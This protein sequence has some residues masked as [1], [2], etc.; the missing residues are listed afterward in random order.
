MATLTDSI[1]AA[2]ARRFIRMLSGVPEAHGR[3][4]RRALNPFSSLRDPSI[5]RLW[6]GCVRA[7]EFIQMLFLG[8]RAHLNL[9]KIHR[10]P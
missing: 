10:A 3:L 1:L 8:P 4:L 6:L 9:A 5:G 7:A 2:Q